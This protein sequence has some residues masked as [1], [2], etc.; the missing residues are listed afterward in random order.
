MLDRLVELTAHQLSPSG[1]PH[2][3]PGVPRPSAILSG[4]LHNDQD[5][6]RFLLLMC[7]E[8][9]ALFSSRAA[10][11]ALVLGEEPAAVPTI[12]SCLAGANSEGV[13]SALL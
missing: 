3:V 5:R 4:R 11:A 8:T 9:G 7:C 10:A 2:L 1:L 6:N 13:E 12:S